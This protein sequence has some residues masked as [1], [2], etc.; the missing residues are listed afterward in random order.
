MLHSVKYGSDQVILHLITR[1]HGRQSYIARIGR[2]TARGAASG[3]TRSLMQPM[4]LLE[5]QGEVAGSDLHRMSQVTASYVLREM[6]F[7]VV[8][9]SIAMFVSEMLYRLTAQEG[10]MDARFYGFIEQSVVALDAM[11]EGV[12]NFHLHFMIRL[13]HFLGYVARSNWQQGAWL[14]IKSGEYVMLSPQHP[15]KVDP[16]IAEL[17]HIMDGL[18]VSQLATIKLSREQRVTIL[19]ALVDYYHYHT[20]AIASVRSLRILAELF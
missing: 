13:T 16:W 1:D 6:P 11:Q 20:E 2:A 17:L 9:S 7:D 5:F 3:A 14:D 12:S 4:F 10:M 15:L 18:E 19:N 8:K